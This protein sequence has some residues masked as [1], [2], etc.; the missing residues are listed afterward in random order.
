MAVMEVKQGEGKLVRQIS[1]TFEAQRYPGQVVAVTPVRHL[2]SGAGYQTGLRKS[3]ITPEEGKTLLSAYGTRT[4]SVGFQPTRKLYHRKRKRQ[5]AL[6][7][8]DGK[9]NAYV[10]AYQS[11]V[12]GQVGCKR[13][14][15]T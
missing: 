1:G 3:T 8:A 15:V 12:L 4:K 7:V 2:N 5:V 9:G 14:K 10:S 13:I 6:T 11:D